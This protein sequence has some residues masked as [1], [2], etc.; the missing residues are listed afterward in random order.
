LHA[1]V[2]GLR[3][4][5]RRGVAVEVGRARRYAWMRASDDEDQHEHEEQKRD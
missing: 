1:S 5:A 4:D 3:G 2:R